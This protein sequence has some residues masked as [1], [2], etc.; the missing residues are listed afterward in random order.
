MTNNLSYGA[1]PR[2]Y[3]QREGPKKCEV[4]NFEATLVA[5][6][7]QSGANIFTNRGVGSF[8]ETKGRIVMMSDIIETIYARS[9]EEYWCIQK[10]WGMKA[11]RAIADQGAKEPYNGVAISPEIVKE[12]V[13]QV[14]ERFDAKIQ[15]RKDRPVLVTSFST[16]KLR[17]YGK[18]YEIERHTRAL[19][20]AW[21]R[22]KEKVP[23]RR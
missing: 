15:I 6:L 1:I 21:S 16:G 20:E 14:E 17:P 5:E 3:H 4:K 19:A 23:N 7:D 12:V 18:L 2:E 8:G 10:R 22:I 9:M 13:K 11:A